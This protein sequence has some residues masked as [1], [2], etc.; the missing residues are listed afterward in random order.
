MQ[1]S[2]A[3]IFDLDGVICHTD[4]FHFHAWKR[5]SDE[6]NMHFDLQLNEQLKGVSR[7]ASYRIIL[8]EN[9][10][11]ESQENIDKAI[12]QKNIYYKEL[13]DQMDE[14]YVS[15]DVLNTLK[16]IKNKGYLIAI[17]S[18]SKNAKF[19][20]SKIKLLDFFDA[21]SDG[22]DIT[23]SKPH[24]E[25]FIKAADK[26]KVD[27]KNC[28]VVEDAYSGVQAG[29]RSK[30]K[31]FAFNQEKTIFNNKDVIKIKKISD[32]LKYI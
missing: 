30:M 18:S 28:Y 2:K 8:K 26:L 15:L 3:I 27:P 19:I 29:L 17:G 20:L 10:R 22:T 12:Y 21:I 16:S 13:L 1:Q 6:K 7:E 31:V 25:V 11:T 4:Q 23:H 24:P 32:I 14:S 5:I 9:N